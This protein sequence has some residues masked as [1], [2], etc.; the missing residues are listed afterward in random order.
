VTRPNAK[1]TSRSTSGVDR[2]CVTFGDKVVISA[3]GRLGIAALVVVLVIIVVVLSGLHW[4][5]PFEP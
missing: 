1:D 3:E 4:T 2:V 5:I